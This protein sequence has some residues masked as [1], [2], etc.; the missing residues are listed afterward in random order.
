[1]RNI[2]LYIAQL[3]SR[4]E[5]AYLPGIGSFSPSYTEAHFDAGQQAFS[6]PVLAIRF[7]PTALS[8]AE[9]DPALDAE[10][11]TLT[12]ALERGEEVLIEGIGTLRQKKSGIR[13]VPIRDNFYA[14]RPI[15][16]RSDLLV[17]V[18]EEFISEVDNTEEPEAL[19]NETTPVNDEVEEEGYEPESNRSWLRWVLVLLLLGLGGYAY[20]WYTQNQG[21]VAPSKNIQNTREKM[22]STDTLTTSQVDSSVQD[23]L[24]SNTQADLPELVH[25]A[26]GEGD[27]EVII[28]SFRKLEEA[29][30]YIVAMRAK[31]Y[32]LRLLQPRRAGNLNKISYGAYPTKEEAIQVL[33]AVRRDLVSG[34]WLFEKPNN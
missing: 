33:R 24:R 29:Q 25:K 1:M 17:P 11:N 20:Y 22:V 7:D 14:L 26:P 19:E 9:I 15:A 5:T 30:E 18:V 28:A 10:L 8:T 27:F 13:F 31:G 4:K 12:K 16:E 23:S 21:K 34:A 32:Q 2:G 6:P 3:L